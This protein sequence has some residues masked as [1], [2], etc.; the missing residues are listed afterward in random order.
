MFSEVVALLKKGKQLSKKHYL[1]PL[2]PFRI[3]PTGMDITNDCTL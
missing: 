2:N 3:F 1:K